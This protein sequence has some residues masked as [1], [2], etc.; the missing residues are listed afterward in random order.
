MLE[1]VKGLLAC[2]LVMMPLLAAQAAEP[3]IQ[4]FTAEDGGILQRVSGNG[5]WALTGFGTTALSESGKVKVVNLQ[6][7]E[8][9]DLQ[10]DAEVEADGT[11]TYTDI[12]DDGETVVGAY[13]GRAAYW[14]RSAR[15]WT[16]LAMP[17]GCT[18][19]VATE[20][21]PDGRY[22]IG[23]GLLSSNE[24]YSQGVLWDLTTGSEVVLSGLPTLDM[25]HENQHQ[26]QFISISDDGRY[27]LGSLSYSYLLP[28]A[29]CVFL[30]DRET[31]TYKFLGFDPSDTQDWTPWVS[32]LAFVDE[33]RISPNG[34]YVVL[35]AWMYE[36]GVGDV[37]NVDG[38]AVA[39][40]N[41]ETGE[42]AVLKGS[43]GMYPSA[44]DN[45]GT[46]YAATPA[47]N[48][49]REWAVF[50]QGYWFPMSQILKQQYGID[51]YAKTGYSNTGTVSDI[52]TDGKTLSVMVDPQGESYTMTLE[53]PIGQMC[54]GISLL[55]NYTISPVSGTS[56]TKLFS[57]EITFDREV[58]FIGNDVKAV[59][60]TKADGTVV[61]KTSGISV[62]NKSKSM[63]VLTFRPQTLAAGE[64]Y[65]VTVPAGIISVAGDATKVNTEIKVTYG[66]RAD[67]PVSVL[68]VYPA[69]G[70]V[71]AKI[72][73]GSNPVAVTFDAEVVLTETPTAELRVLEEDGYEKI[74][75]LNTYVNEKSLYVYPTSTQY[76][77]DE[78]QY[79]VLIGAGCVTDL[80]GKGAN[81]EMVLN[82]TGSY[83]RE[84]SHDNASLFKDDFANQA[85][86]L[87]NFMRYEGDHLTP[88]T[89]MQG[90]GFSADNQPWNFSI[91]DDNST[92]YC[93]ASTSMYTTIGQSDDWMVIPQLEIPDEYVNLTFKAQ[94]YKKAKADRLKVLVWECEENINALNTE[95]IKR[96]K[97]EAQVVFDEQLTPGDTEGVL[98]DEWTNYSVSLAAYSGKKIYIAFLN[99][100]TNQSA[101]FVDDV[102][103]LREMKFFVSLTS[104]GTVVNKESI[105][106][107][108]TLVAN[109]ENETYTSAK[110][111]L[112]DHNGNDVEEMVLTGFSLSKGDKLD[113]AFSKPLPLVKGVSNKCK[114]EVEMGNHKEDVECTIKN[115]AFE[116][117]KRVVIEEYTGVTCGACPQ[118]IV[119][120]EHLKELYGS[121]VVPVAIHTYSGDPFAS[122]LS[123]YSGFL[124]LS[125][126]P[127]A[128]I[129]R[130]GIIASPMSTDAN[131]KYTM[132]NGTTL[133]K[134][135]VAAEFETP[136]DADITAEYIVSADS[137][138]FDLPV[139]IKYAM[140]AANL[141][142]NIFLVMLEDS[143][144]TYQ[145]NYFSGVNDPVLGEFGAGGKYGQSVV[146]NFEH[147][148]IARACWGSSYNGTAGLLPQSMKAGEEYTAQLTGF[149]M[150]EGIYSAKNTK[151]VVMLIDGNTD[152]LINAVCVK[153]GM[154]T[155]IEDVKENAASCRIEAAEGSVQVT[156]KGSIT[157]QAYTAAGVLLST[158]Q[159]KDAV[160]LSTGSH[161]GVVIVKA[162][163][164]GKITVRKLTL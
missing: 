153:P 125:A 89:E 66:G 128:V 26:Q 83:I 16:E 28:V 50:H 38:D 164:D 7:G 161:R 106:I 148:D 157:A 120:I 142:L 70:S 60:L 34:K 59:T 72:D 61:A 4:K 36:A 87:V 159:G 65:T 71:L 84:V 105:L 19:S 35:H 8:S 49:L 137:T 24:Y 102:S 40:Y 41:V 140:D 21:T 91:R 146:F 81:K 22:A 139:T 131:G 118:G 147:H 12:A 103:V 86:S 78:K 85:Q 64:K 114:I 116:P 56:F 82:Y 136:T 75:D 100:N 45:D 67:Q 5:K 20:I 68:G 30:Y 132:S 162:E 112:R 163:V 149:T 37:A 46:V 9:E 134:D 92:D 73:N 29:P 52:S 109:V 141:N 51:F 32:G 63:I 39:S 23:R 14:K 1:K 121:K 80:S 54:D 27:I 43:D 44:V 104:Q 76:L 108:G 11:Q 62:S 138:S 88:N 99:D 155:A 93:A 117:T 96:L 48:P 31:S 69:D 94:S 119:A 58:D 47:G 77:Y 129:Q 115:L 113:F 123:D 55:E 2:L 110:L 15:Q 124:G 156:G 151:M 150:P 101:I 6:T 97:A 98:A 130:S 79:Q 95:I 13:K 42:F 122:G 107:A 143:I 158:V 3:V 53:K 90:W 111:T 152:K 25:S 135:L 18:G 10:T 133:W 154:S 145:Q 144:I 127:S 74:C 57:V 160:S 33:G 126:A 17:A